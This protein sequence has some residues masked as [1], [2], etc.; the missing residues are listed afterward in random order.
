MIVIGKTDQGFIV[1]MSETEIYNLLGFYARSSTGAVEIR[2][3]M[4]INVHGMFDRIRALDN[5]PGQLKKA[6]EDLAR[7]SELLTSVNP[8]VKIGT[9]GK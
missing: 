7:V 2:S 1:T 8:I 3:G 4:D 5:A 6:Q 9:E